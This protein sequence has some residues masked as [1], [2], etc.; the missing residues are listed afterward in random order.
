MPQWTSTPEVRERSLGAD[1]DFS[2]EQITRLIDDAE[3]V[4]LAAFPA[5]ESQVPDPIPL[6]RVA[7]V[8][9]GMVIRRLRNPDGIRT[10][11]DSTGPYSG[12]TTYAG[13]HPGEIYLSEED[14]RALTV[15]TA[16]GRRAF[17]VMPNYRR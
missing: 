14:K 5:I 17:S 6:A 1:D 3:D 4:V 7:R 16:S 10:L 12:S 15:G 9:S 2:D 13:D 8:V 11:Q